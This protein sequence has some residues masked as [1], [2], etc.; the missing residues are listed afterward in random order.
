MILFGLTHAL[1]NYLYPFDPTMTMRWRSFRCHQPQNNIFITKHTHTNTITITV[2]ITRYDTMS[3]RLVSR[4][5]SRSNSRFVNFEGEGSLF[6]CSYAKS[7]KFQEFLS[8]SCCYTPKN[9]HSSRGNCHVL[10]LSNY[11]I[12]GLL[13]HS[14]AINGTKKGRRISRS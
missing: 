11:T 14:I 4:S 2:C 7:L 1:Y 5:R 9:L 13:A 10:H 6:I 8:C 12:C 3:M